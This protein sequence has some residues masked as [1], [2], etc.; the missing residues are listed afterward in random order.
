M[1]F[2]GALCVYL[3]CEERAMKMK[4]DALCIK[5]NPHNG[6]RLT[7]FKDFGLKKAIHVVRDNI[8]AQN[9]EGQRCRFPISSQCKSLDH[10]QVSIIKP[11]TSTPN[12]FKMIQINHSLE[13]NE[14]LLNF[15][16]SCFIT[17][18]LLMKY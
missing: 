5:S 6:F 15:M 4:K 17:L 9:H 2:K 11:S 14:K 7:P 13:E 1:Y 12:S 16:L 10:V 8:I 18:E 3:Y